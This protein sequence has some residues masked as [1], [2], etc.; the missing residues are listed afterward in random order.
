VYSDLVLTADLG[1][2]W[3]RAA[4]VKPDGRLQDRVEAP[5]PRGDRTAHA[6][7]RLVEPLAPGCSHAVLGL[8]G[9]IHHATGVL[10]HAPNLPV[11]WKPQ[12]SRAALSEALAMT[13]QTANDADLAAIGEGWFGAARGYRDVVFL[14]FSTG[15]GGGVLLDGRLARGQRSIAEVGWQVI[16]RVAAARGEP[17]QLEHLASGEALGRLGAEAGI[18]GGGAEVVRRME[19]GDPVAAE[20]FARVVDA[21]ALGVVNVAYLYSPEIVVIGGS[22]GLV[23]PAFLDPIRARL[24]D[25]GPPGLGTLVVPAALGPDAGLIGAAAWSRATSRR[26]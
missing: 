10:E 12:L 9:R 11:S 5:T 2:S 20:V 24:A 4:R 23:G 19:A 16:D 18:H 25:L 22:L 15:V 1:G 3:M 8:P 26:G 13:V 6:F 21:A 14:T 7:I 17:C